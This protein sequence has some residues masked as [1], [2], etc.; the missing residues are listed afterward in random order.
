MNVLKA[1]KTKKSPKLTLW[2]K[3]NRYAKVVGED[4]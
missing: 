1:K 3:G 2:A 4:C